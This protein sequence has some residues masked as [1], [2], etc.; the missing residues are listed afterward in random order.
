LLGQPRLYF[1][2]FYPSF[3]FD[4]DAVDFLIRNGPYGAAF[5]CSSPFGAI[6]FA[7]SLGIFAVS[8][9][10]FFFCCQSFFLYA[11]FP[12]DGGPFPSVSTHFA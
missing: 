2:S 1:R 11:V 12:L 9:D 7:P 3:L 5:V 10:F 8:W 6:K 4:L